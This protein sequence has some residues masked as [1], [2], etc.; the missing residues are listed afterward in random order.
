LG[1]RA[2]D[3]LLT[4]HYSVPQIL[5]IATRKW[6]LTSRPTRKRPEKALTLNGLYNMFTNTFYYGEYEYPHGSGNWHSCKHKPMITREEYDRGQVLLGRT[7][8]PRKKKHNFTFTGLIRCAECGAMV[9][10]EE[11]WKHQQNGNRHHYI[12]YH[13]TKRKRPAC[14]QGSIEEKRLLEDVQAALENIEI[15][16][17]MTEWAEKHIEELRESDSRDEKAVSNSAKDQLAK[18]ER[19]LQELTRMRYQSLIDDDEFQRERGRLKQSQA[20]I[21]QMIH[22]GGTLAD[23]WA[24]AALHVYRMAESIRTR[25]A[26]TTPIE[27]KEM[28]SEIGSNL[29]LKDK[30]LLFEARKPFLIIQK[31]Y[32]K[33]LDQFG[34]FEPLTSGYTKPRNP[35]FLAAFELVCSSVN[36]VRTYL[37]K[38]EEKRQERTLVG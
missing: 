15:P 34:G 21:R 12:Y 4:G 3:L 25:F 18:A 35:S 19:A 38:E 2:W 16:P 31:Y 8:R 20:Q 22:S 23:S 28:L 33:A 32:R 7:D 37:I 24:N 30:M 26:V 17:L 13:C 6:G 10:A 11:K 1:R 36:E 9:T 14:T 5:E 29:V 27:Q